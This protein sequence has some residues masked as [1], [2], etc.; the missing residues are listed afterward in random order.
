M[1]VLYAKDP[2]VRISYPDFIW[3]DGLYITE[4]QKSTARVH[5]IPDELLRALWRVGDVSN[6]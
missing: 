2:N 1:A 3:D 5:K 4:T 6:E